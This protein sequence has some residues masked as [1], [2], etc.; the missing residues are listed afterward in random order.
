MRRKAASWIGC[1][2][3]LGLL[4][5]C[6]GFKPR[7]APFHV[8]NS[9]VL[10]ESPKPEHPKEAR[11]DPLGVDPVEWRYDPQKGA[12]VEGQAPPPPASKVAAKSAPS[13]DGV[14]VKPGAKASIDW[15][16]NGGSAEVV[17]GASALPKAPAPAVAPPR[18][19]PAPAPRVAEDVAPVREAAAPGGVA[20]ADAM[21]V[22]G[23]EHAARYIQALYKI[24]GV[25]LDVG[26]GEQTIAA[27]H[28]SFVRRG[29]IYHVT[30]PAVGDV[31]FFH[32]TFDR[33]GDGRSN[34]W[35]TH[36]GLVEGVDEDGTIHVLSFINGRVESFPINLEHPDVARAPGSGKT[37]NHTLRRRR[38]DDLPFT[39]YLGGELFA[40]FGSLLGDRD[41]LIVIDNW[42]PGMSLDGI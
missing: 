42:T 41:E 34:D 13:A 19:A 36:V 9:A 16:L 21:E 37:W 30:R 40:G 4:S 27:M 25:E 8:Y 29:R 22:E 23:P 26:Q 39:Q 24:N 18:P 3:V 38:G 10:N 17:S 32:N 5:A 1:L 31:V 15:K 28:E 7:R 12:V 33:N 20:V 2:L 6:G 35:Y 14:D 11:F